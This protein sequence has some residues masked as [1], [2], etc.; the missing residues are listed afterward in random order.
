MNVELFMKQMNGDHKEGIIE[1]HIIKQYVPLEEKIAE[2]KK[3]VE[4]SCYTNVPVEDGKEQRVFRINT[5][6]KEFYT[7]LALLNLYTDIELSEDILGDYNKLA[8]KKYTKKILT[9]MPEDAVDF[10]TIL[11][12]TFQDEIENVSAIGNV[13]NRLLSSSNSIFS[14]VINEMVE[15]E[16]KNGEQENES[17]GG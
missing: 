17:N 4:L 16:I 6:H 5:V 14:A 8:E 12:M 13:V 10:N 11:N 1:K 9:A 3:V 2:A 15:R 7:F